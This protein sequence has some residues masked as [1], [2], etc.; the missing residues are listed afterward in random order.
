MRLRLRRSDKVVI[1][2]TLI[3]LRQLQ[4]AAADIGGGFRAVGNA[5]ELAL[6]RR[7]GDERNDQA[8]DQR[9]YD[10]TYCGEGRFINCAVFG[11][12]HDPVDAAREGG[13]PDGGRN[14]ASKVRAVQ[15]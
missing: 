7:N 2:E 4:R 15:G 13:K 9:N 1:E 3:G 11:L 14:E 5:L 8:D 12:R 10:G 6:H